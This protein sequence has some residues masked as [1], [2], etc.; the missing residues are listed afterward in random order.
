M[1]DSAERDLVSTLKVQ[2]VQGGR[3]YFISDIHL[4]DGSHTDIFLQKDEH[5][6]ALLDRVEADASALVILGDFLDLEQAWYFTRIVR[7]H[8]EVITRLTK[9]A[10]RMQV[11]Y[12]YGNHDPDIVLFRDILRMQL[13][14]KVEV[15]GHVLAVH[16]YEFDSY[17]GRRFEASGWATRLMTLYERLFRTRI[18]L[19]LRDNYTLSNRFVHLLLAWCSHIGS[20]LGAIGGRL[21]RPQLGGALRTVV[22][23]WTRGVLGD[24]MGITL[25]AVDYLQ[26][27]DRFDTVICGHSHVPGV[28]E[29]S[30][31]QTFVNTGSWSFGN[32]QYGILGAGGFELY[33]WMTGRRIL[34]E[35]YRAI[36]EGKAERSYLDWFA[37]EYLGYGRFRCGE[38][39]L[40]EGVRPRPWVLEG[41]AP[42]HHT[43]VLTT[44]ARPPSET[45]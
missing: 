17:V 19:P 30:G 22:E 40:R 9:L 11:V 24:P 2:R 42:L 32:S 10:E 31:G 41:G 34:D 21:G 8:R 16:G 15:D 6:L 37:D 26:S 5:F 7:A 1:S 29:V 4:G 3:I 27:E 14:D 23:F 36:F 25:P 38:E 43:A 18:R 33:D 13:C 39:A 45:E 28:V 20:W 44:G 35:N 12:V